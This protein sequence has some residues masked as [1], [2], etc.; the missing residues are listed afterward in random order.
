MKT[1][2]KYVSPDGIEFLSAD[3][4]RE[5]ERRCADLIELFK[6]TSADRIQEVLE[7][8]IAYAKT[9]AEIRPT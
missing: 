1:V 2:V 3:E 7:T 6:E 9:R 5:H 8:A 4:C